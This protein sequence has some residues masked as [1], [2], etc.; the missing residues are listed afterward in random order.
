MSPFNTKTKQSLH[1]R[2]CRVR[3][4]VSNYLGRPCT[5]WTN[6]REIF[7]LVQPINITS[8][9]TWI[10]DKQPLLGTLLKTKSSCW[11]PSYGFPVELHGATNVHIIQ[12]P[13]SAHVPDG[14]HSPGRPLSLTTLRHTKLSLCPVGGETSMFSNIILG[15]GTAGL[16]SRSTTV[17]FNGD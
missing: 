4:V 17:F 5:D 11:L 12:H 10:L 16:H 14:I 15:H 13:C 3:L 9:F 2:F 8:S 7:E 6:D 1:K